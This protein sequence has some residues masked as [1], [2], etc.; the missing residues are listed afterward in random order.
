MQSRKL[1]PTIV[2]P[3]LLLGSLGLL[4][5][6]LMRVPLRNS[7]E[8]ISQ[9]I[10]PSPSTSMPTASVETTPQLTPTTPPLPT[11]TSTPLVPPPTASS[12]AS[13]AATNTVLPGA[14][15]TTISTATAVSSSTVPA[16][17]SVTR[18]ATATRT[19]T[20]TPS[21]TRTVMPRI[22]ITVWPTPYLTPQPNATTIAVV[23]D[24]FSGRITGTV[25][26]RGTNTTPLNT[27]PPLISYEVEEVTLPMPITLEWLLPDATG[28]LLEP[29]LVTFDR[30]W[31]LTVTGGPFQVG[32][33]DWTIWLDDKIVGRS[34][35][36]DSSISVLILDPSLLREGAA[37][38]VS[39]GYYKP[40]PDNYLPDSLH[41]QRPPL[42]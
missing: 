23:G 9:Q 10:T 1:N 40:R 34:L 31:H 14:T 11:D 13:P 33:N 39:R 18:T 26:A 30:A 20:A 2:L 29:R 27:L 5:I 24:L 3:L 38:G 4:L 41:F 15:G 12:I 8:E 22:T 35:G 21:A 25:I 42:R 6:V 16:T 36:G 32:N 28:I 37:I 17:P 7:G 19:V